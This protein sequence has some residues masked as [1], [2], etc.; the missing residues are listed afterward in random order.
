MTDLPD[1]PDLSALLEAAE[2]R[3]DHYARI[4][5]EAQSELEKA[6]DYLARLSGRKPRKRRSRTQASSRERITEDTLRRVVEAI[7]SHDYAGVKT[8]AGDTRYSFSHSSTAANVAVER[9]FATREK[10]GNKWRYRITDN[11]M[12][13]VCKDKEVDDEQQQRAQAA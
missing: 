4:V 5:R 11:G 6:D 1:L 13:Y 3:R 9:G 8:I 10:T 7:G 12:E 2:Q